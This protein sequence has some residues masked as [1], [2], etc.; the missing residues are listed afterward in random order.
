MT[1]GENGNRAAQYVR[2]LP[3]IRRPW[4]PGYT[5]RQILFFAFLRGAPRARP[6]RG[7]IDPDSTDGAGC[8]GAARS[9]S[10]PAIAWARVRPVLL[11]TVAYTEIH[12]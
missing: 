4:L 6:V 7:R 8:L 3:V 11:L 12:M 1:S 5:G 10:K 2:H 9:S